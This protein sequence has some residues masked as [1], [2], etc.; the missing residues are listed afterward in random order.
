M[1]IIAGIVCV[2][3]RCLAKIGK[4]ESNLCTFCNVSEETIAHIFCKCPIVSDFW[5]KVAA[6]IKEETNLRILDTSRFE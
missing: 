1:S 5:R 3:P 6:W 2:H 4:I